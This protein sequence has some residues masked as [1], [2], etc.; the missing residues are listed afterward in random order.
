MKIGINLALAGIKAGIGI[1]SKNLVENLLNVDSKNEY[2]LFSPVDLNFNTRNANLVKLKKYRTKL[3]RIYYENF[4]LYK[5]AEEINLDIFHSPAFILPLR[6]KTKSIITLHDFVYKYYKHTL[7]AFKSVYFNLM[8][9][10]SIKRADAIITPSESIREALITEYP[11]TAEKSFVIP[12][13]SGFESLFS[14]EVKVT[15]NILNKYNIKLPY[16]LFVSTIEPRKNLEGL[17]E[18][19]K[20]VDK[21]NIFLVVVGN[22]GWKYQKVKHLI[23]KYKLQNRIIFTGSVGTE[24]LQVI[25]SNSEVFLYPSFYEGFG[26]PILEAMRCGIPI[27]TSGMGA[28]KETAGDAALFINP[29]NPKSIADAINTLLNNEKIKN[30]LIKKGYERVNRFSWKKTALETINIYKEIV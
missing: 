17:I 12:E 5:K 18:A 26:I 6:I 30:N 20:Y 16:L 9:P 8:M 13:S 7:P 29:F 27:I 3:G 14:F 1:Y 11:E 2:Y 21:K 10:Q 15:E 28:T 24:E 19:L 22:F 23:E 4:I 25:Y